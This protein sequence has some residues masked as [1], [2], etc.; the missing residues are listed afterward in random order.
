MKPLHTLNILIG[1][2]RIV[3]KIYDLPNQVSTTASNVTVA[4][5]IHAEASESTTEQPTKPITATKAN[6]IRLEQGS[7]LRRNWKS[8]RETNFI[9]RDDAE[10]ISVVEACGNQGESSHADSKQSELQSVKNS[11]DDLEQE[12]KDSKEHKCVLR[13]IIANSL[14]T[15]LLF[16]LHFI[17]YTSA[18][19]K[20]KKF[21]MFYFVRTLNTLLRLS[22][23]IFSPIYCFEVVHLLFLQIV[24][25][26]Q[27]YMLNLYHRIINSAF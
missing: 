24:E 16:S 9:D 15:V 25:N 6:S 19:I 7:D 13:A 11:L 4:A 5:Q 1:N 18:P 14:I 8:G 3:H 22:A 21:G 12:Y 23:T 20:N 2:L 10:R 26:V 17:I 27:D